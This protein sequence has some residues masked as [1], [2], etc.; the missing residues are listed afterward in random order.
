MSLKND[1]NT[2][3]RRRLRI[4]KRVLGTVDCPRLSLH[5]SCKHLYAQCINDDKGESLVYLSTVS[6]K[7]SVNFKINLASVSEFGHQFGKLASEKGIVRV[8]FDRGVKKYH[9]RV[10]AFA[11]AVREEGVKF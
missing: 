10:K 7:S 8:V 3:K 1:Q 6:G 9:G 2:I 4:R 11:D 5:F